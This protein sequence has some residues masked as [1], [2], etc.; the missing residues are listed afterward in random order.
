RQTWAFGVGKFLTDPVWWFFLFWLPKFLQNTFHLSLQEIVLP[1]I[2]V[3]NAASIGSVGG[4]WLSSNLIRRGWSINAARQ[5]TMLICALC[6]LPVFAIP[7]LTSL[8]LVV[9]VVSL[10]LA[11]HQG[12]SANLFTTT[13][14]MFPRAAVGSVVGIG[15]A[16]GALGNFLIQEAAGWVLKSTGSYFILFMICGSAYLLALAIFQLLAPKL[17]P[18]E[19]D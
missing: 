10:A 16:A 2:V 7:F 8:W 1:T 19:L 3:Y 14:D 12:W 5:T 11:A 17:Q 4:G 9:G 18:V 15:A 13:S 6:L